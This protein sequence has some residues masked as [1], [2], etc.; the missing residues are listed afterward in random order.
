MVPALLRQSFAE[1]A[2][3]RYAAA[4]TGL[5][6]QRLPLAAGPPPRSHHRNAPTALSEVTTITLFESRREINLGT[7]IRMLFESQCFDDNLNA[8]SFDDFFGRAP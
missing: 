3:H 2:H 1:R 5:E 4:D 7:P 8:G 6:A